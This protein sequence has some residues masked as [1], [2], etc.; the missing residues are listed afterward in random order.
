MTD[1]PRARPPGIQVRWLYD[2]FGK[3]VLD[4]KC[5][6]YYNMYSSEESILKI[7]VKAK[8]WWRP[9]VVKEVREAANWACNYHDLT[10]SPIPIHIKLCGPSDI[11]GDSVDLDHKIV[12]R[13]FACEEWL[14]T[15]FHEMTHAYQYVY[16]RLQLE[17]KHAY[18]L[19]NLLVRD[20][21]KYQQ[22]P[23]EIE[24]RKFE[25]EM[26]QKFLTLVP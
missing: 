12:I 7:R 18:W 26:T 23:W 14:P 25:E 5:C 8:K 6:W 3:I 19:G 4:L 10:V 2:Y 17:F 13:L 11:Y 24:A 15:L 16:G 1:K 22:E 20:E 21:L 9:D